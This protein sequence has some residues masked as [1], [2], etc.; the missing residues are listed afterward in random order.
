MYDIEE[1]KV[2]NLKRREMDHTENIKSN[3]SVIS[4]KKGFFFSM[5]DA[6]NEESKDQ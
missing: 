2:Q 4:I 6:F 5:H 1:C 3:G